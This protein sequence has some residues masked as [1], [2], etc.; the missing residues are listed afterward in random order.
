MSYLSILCVMML[1]LSFFG[2]IG[3]IVNSLWGFAIVF[4]VFAIIF[5]G[6][7]GITMRKR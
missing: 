3:C 4:M 5:A 1:M 7:F 2:I 6:F